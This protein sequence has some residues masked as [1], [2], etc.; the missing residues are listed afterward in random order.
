MA[1]FRRPTADDGLDDD[2]DGGVPRTGDAATSIR[3]R[4]PR[5]LAPEALAL[6]PGAD[7]DTVGRV[8]ARPDGG[9][10]SWVAEAPYPIRSERTAPAPPRAARDGTAQS[11]L[12]RLARTIETEI[13]PNLVRAGR[14]QRRHAAAPVPRDLKPDLDDVTEFANLVLMRGDRVAAS[15]IDWLRLRGT[16]ME[17]IYLDLLAPSARHLGTLWEE[18]LADFTQVT[19][20]LGR[21]QQI[22]REMSPAFLNETELPLSGRRALILPVAGEQHTFGLLMV[23]DFFTRA[24]WAVKALPSAT[25]SEAGALVRREWFGLVGFSLSN[26]RFASALESEIRL[27]RKTSRN[28]GLTVMAGG[29]VFVENPDLAA[30]LGA[31]AT[32]PDGPSAAAAADGIVVSAARA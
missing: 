12:T 13:V 2:S 15:Y 10:G 19:V 5:P 11:G 27:V 32:A 6:R 1:G 31:D 20:G 21:L 14:S 23:S 9:V 30:R 24:G 7:L 25:A 26:E 16:S 3:L 28:P 4:D 22:M 17:S 29:P 8:C 18:D